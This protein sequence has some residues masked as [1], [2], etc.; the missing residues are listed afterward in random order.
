VADAGRGMSAYIS[1]QHQ[2]L[3]QANCHRLHR[4]PAALQIL[5]WCCGQRASRGGRDWQQAQQL[6]LM[7]G[8]EQVW[9]WRL[10]LQ[11]AH[12]SC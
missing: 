11:T 7:A 12:H 1:A 8:L 2:R 4:K 5:R 3:P 6:R 10:H 9:R